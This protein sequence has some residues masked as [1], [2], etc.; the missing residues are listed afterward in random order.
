MYVGQVLKEI[1]RADN[2]LTGTTKSVCKVY[3]MSFRP[4]MNGSL[5]DDRPEPSA[6][7]FL[8]THWLSNYSGESGVDRN[9]AEARAMERIRCATVELAEAFAELG[10][11]GTTVLGPSFHPPETEHGTVRFSLCF[12]FQ[13]K[14]IATTLTVLSIDILVHGPLR[15]QCLLSHTSKSISSP[16]AQ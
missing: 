16:L 3:L 4:I 6:V 10:A 1:S 15:F 7:P 5:T 11:F 14:V 2:F 8:I 12:H 13:I 9:V